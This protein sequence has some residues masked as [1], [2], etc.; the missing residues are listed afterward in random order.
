MG[1]AM[2]DA[3][4]TVQCAPDIFSPYNSRETPIARPLGRAMGVFRE[5]LV[6][7]KFYI[8]I[9]VLY[10]VSCD[11][12]SRYIESLQYIVWFVIVNR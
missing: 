10:A 6:R 12:V 2:N 4:Q 9:S 7:P 1:V 5:I 11:M 8:R 3:Y